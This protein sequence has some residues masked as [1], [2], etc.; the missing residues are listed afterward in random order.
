MA[1]GNKMTGKNGNKITVCLGKKSQE[2]K[3]Q[4]NFIQRL[5]Y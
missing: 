1:G 3:S 4:N 2:I 5:S